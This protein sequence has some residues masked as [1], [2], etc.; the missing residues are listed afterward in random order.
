VSCRSAD[1]CDNGPFASDASIYEGLAL[2]GR[3]LYE[4]A[5]P[6]VEMFAH[7]SFGHTGGARSIC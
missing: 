4:R 1:C 2:Y 7:G 3:A 6:W 5:K